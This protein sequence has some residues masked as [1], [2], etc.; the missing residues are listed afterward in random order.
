[1]SESREP[2]HLPGMFR[3]ATAVRVVLA[4]ARRRPKHA[5]EVSEIHWEAG[6]VEA[7]EVIWF[8]LDDGYAVGIVCTTDPVHS[9]W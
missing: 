7:Q 6:V 5:L 1:M 3:H 8:H 9:P 2:D 4:D